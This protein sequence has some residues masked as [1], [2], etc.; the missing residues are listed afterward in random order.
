MTPHHFSI[1]TLGKIFSIKSG[2]GFTLLEVI[3]A[4]SFLTVAVGGSFGLL[5]QTLLTASL[6]NSKLIAS[7]LAQ[8]GIEIV[9]NIRDNNWLNQRAVPGLSW[10]GGLDAGTYEV[11]YGDPSLA[12]LSSP[13]Y[14]R[15]LYINDTDGFYNYSQVGTKTKFK[16]IITV[17]P[18][19][20][21]TLDVGVKVEWQERIAGTQSIEIREYLY[22]WYGY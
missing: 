5:Q 1:N 15:N 11:S 16:R 7:Y 10:K 19:G 12:S 4:I 17:S 21:D 2:G 14:A 9:R 22:N 13:D 20:D 8:E 18:V 6:A 3:L